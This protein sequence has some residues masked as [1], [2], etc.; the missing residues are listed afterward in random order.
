MQVK[1]FHFLLLFFLLVL[2]LLCPRL[3]RTDQ[4]KYKQIL[5]MQQLKAR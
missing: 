4:T 5:L 2:Q 1:A 3:Q